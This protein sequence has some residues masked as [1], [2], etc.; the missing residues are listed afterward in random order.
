MS[1]QVGR[2]EQL[3]SVIEMH[4]LCAFLRGLC[5]NAEAEARAVVEAKLLVGVAIPAAAEARR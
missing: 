3:V 4:T 5:L 1:G 2:G